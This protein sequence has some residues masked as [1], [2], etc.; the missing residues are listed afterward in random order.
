MKIRNETKEI[1]SDKHTNKKEVD[2]SNKLKSLD[3]IQ[4]K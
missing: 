2:I 4:F 3:L 1:L